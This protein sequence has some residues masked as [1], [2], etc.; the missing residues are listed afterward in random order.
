MPNVTVSQP[1]VIKVQVG[2]KPAAVQSINY[3]SKT[4]RGS[5]DLSIPPNA[6]S[7][8]VIIYN[9]ANNNF[10][11]TSISAEIGIIDGGLF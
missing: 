7:G 4:L 2:N 5:T 3:G 8:D 1:A 11:V 9:S 10:S 6:N